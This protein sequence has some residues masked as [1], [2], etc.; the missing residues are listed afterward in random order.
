ML[1]IY[2]FVIDYAF[3]DFGF[4]LFG[5]LPLGLGLYEQSRRNKVKSIRVEK[6]LF[7]LAMEH[8]RLLTISEIILYSELD[9]HTAE[10]ALDELRRR[11]LVKI[12]VAENGI[13][14]YEFEP[15]LSKEQKILAE[16]V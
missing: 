13:W 14:V 2:S 16:R 9:Q 15:L 3:F 11:G 6:E 10:Q 7:K 4:F 1:Y 5:I 8:D 12:K